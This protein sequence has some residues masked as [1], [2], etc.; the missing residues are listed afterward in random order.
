MQFTWLLSVSKLMSFILL[1]L[2]FNTTSAR[3]YNTRGDYETDCPNVDQACCKYI[4]HVPQLAWIT[5]IFTFKGE[6][7]TPANVMIEYWNPDT[8]QHEPWFAPDLESDGHFYQ[9]VNF[10][11]DTSSKTGQHLGICVSQVSTQSYAV[12]LHMRV[13]LAWEIN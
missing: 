7:Y 9:Q 13:Y 5:I 1:A 8:G 11:R 4:E 2:W 10:N 3:K 12:P 6:L